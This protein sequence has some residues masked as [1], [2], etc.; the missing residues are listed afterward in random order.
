M[1][2]WPL[3]AL[4]LWAQGEVRRMGGRVLQGERRFL[5]GLGAWREK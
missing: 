5:K 4:P 3:D 2:P 1:C